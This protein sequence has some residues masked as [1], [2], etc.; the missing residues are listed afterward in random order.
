MFL[1]AELDVD[2]FMEIPAGMQAKDT[3]MPVTHDGGKVKYVLKLHKNLY[4]LNQAVYNWYNMFQE[5]LARR[6]FV[7][8]LIDECDF[9]SD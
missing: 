1:Q 9:Y 7:A 8:S 4:G 2:I 6:D 3:T 5:G